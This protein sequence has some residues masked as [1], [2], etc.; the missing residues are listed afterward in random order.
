[1]SIF[2]DASALVALLTLEDGFE[3]LA[4]LIDAEDRRYTSG[5]SVWEATLAISRNWG[6]MLDIAREDV[7]AFLAARNIQVVPIGMAEATIALDA[8]RRFGKGR[9]EARLNMG[10]CFSYACAKAHDARLL[11]KGDDFAET[12]LA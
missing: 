10:D 8:H 5:L 11:Y 1:M 4:D 7:N 2:V 9:H 6:V 12:D 3:V